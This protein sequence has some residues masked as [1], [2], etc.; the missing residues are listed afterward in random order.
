MALKATVA[1]INTVPEAHRTEYKQVGNEWRLDIEGEIPG[2]VPQARF[3]EFRDNNKLLIDSEKALKEKLEALKDIDPLE[4][5]RLK[6]KRPT[7]TEKEFQERLQGALKPLQDELATRKSTEEKLTGEIT[8]L[9]INDAALAAGAELGVLPT[10]QQDLINRIRNATTLENG[11]VTIW[12]TKDGER[13]KRYSTKTGNLLTVKELVAEMA[14]TTAPHLFN[15][16]TGTGSGGGGGNTN[17]GGGR[18][19]GNGRWQGPNPFDRKGNTWNV[20]KQGELMKMDRTLAKTMADACGV[21]VAGLTDI[22]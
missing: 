13:V 10:G 1:D 19:Q 20:T 8:T 14:E 5:K 21:R 15:P 6:E 12:E 2:F 3:V 4:Y 18:Q 9:K 7:E 11:V 16:S 22:K 17:G